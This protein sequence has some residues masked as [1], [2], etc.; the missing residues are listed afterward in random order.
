M[1]TPYYLP[2]TP[3]KRQVFAA[4]A[5]IYFC[6]QRLSDSQIFLLTFAMFSIYFSGIMVR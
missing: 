2:P 6:F 3:K 1:H 5:G 4:P